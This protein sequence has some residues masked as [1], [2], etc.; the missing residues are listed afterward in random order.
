MLDL[1]NTSD[2]ELVVLYKQGRERAFDELYS[3]YEQKLKRL[4]YYY[5]PN[6]EEVD[7]VFHNVFIRV[8]R[9]IKSYDTKKNFS[10]WIYTIAVNCSKNY[11]SRVKRNETLVEKE[12]FKLRENTG[13]GQTPEESF[14]SNYTMEEFN[15]ALEELNRKFRDV[16]ILRMD[17]RMKYSEIAEVLQCSER[18]AKWRM[19]KCVEKIAVNLKEK[20]LL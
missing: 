9:H 18:T 5:I 14:I 1:A 3:R 6:A 10:S 2:E 8:I 16:F 20:G 4:I 19:K 13:S 11:I 17:H 12:K 7:D 15:R